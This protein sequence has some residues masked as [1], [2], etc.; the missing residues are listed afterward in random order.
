MTFHFD[1]GIKKPLELECEVLDAGSI[2]LSPVNLG[3][4][5]LTVEAYSGVHDLD[6]D[7]AVFILVALYRYLAAGLAPEEYSMPDSI[8]HKELH[9]KVVQKI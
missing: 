5:F 8:L 1:I 2:L 4:Y 7:I 6:H 3:Q 9:C